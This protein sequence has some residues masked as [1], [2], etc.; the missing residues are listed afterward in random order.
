[1]H[2]YCIVLF[3]VQTLTSQSSYSLIC[4]DDREC[5]S[6]LGWATNKHKSSE[7]TTSYKLHPPSQTMD[8]WWWTH[9]SLK[10]K[11]S[12]MSPRQRQNDTADSSSI[13]TH[14]KEHAFNVNFQRKKSSY[15]YLSYPANTYTLIRRHFRPINC[16]QNT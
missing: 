5:P 11:S 8:K 15:N 12:R 13:H 3:C 4:S 16:K 9:M 2:T 10:R 14:T 7:K 1:M 6:G